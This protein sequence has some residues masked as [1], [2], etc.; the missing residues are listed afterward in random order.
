MH[1]ETALKLLAGCQKQH[2]AKRKACVKFTSGRHGL[3]S[4]NSRN[5]KSSM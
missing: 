3:T 1:T 4:N 2:L 5:K